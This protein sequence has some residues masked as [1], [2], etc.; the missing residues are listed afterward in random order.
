[1]VEGSRLAGHIGVAMLALGL[2]LLA[3]WILFDVSRWYYAVGFWI[4]TPGAWFIQRSRK[5]SSA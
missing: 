3:T 2:G 5:S 1:M 4:G